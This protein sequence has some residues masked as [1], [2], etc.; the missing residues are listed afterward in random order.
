M[1]LVNTPVFTPSWKA[2][3]RVTDTRR[4]GNTTQD[5]STARAQPAPAGAFQNRLQLLEHKLSAQKVQS[6]ASKGRST[7]TFSSKDK[8]AK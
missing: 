8:G 1:K 7:L 2:Q 6:E 5:P 3:E 4:A